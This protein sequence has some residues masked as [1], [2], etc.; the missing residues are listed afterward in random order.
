MSTAIFE[1]SLSIPERISELERLVHLA[2]VEIDRDEKAYNTPCR[3]CCILLASHLEGFL[4]DLT[5]SLIYD[6]NFHL[7]SFA[8]MPEAMKRT[9]CEKIAFYEGVPPDDINHRTKQLVKFFSDHTVPIDLQAFHYKENKNKNPSPDFVD[10]ILAKLGVPSVLSSISDGPLDNIFK[11]ENSLS[12]MIR[13]DMRKFRSYLHKFPYRTLPI[14]YTFIY[15]GKKGGKKDESLWNTYIDEILLRRH[16]IVHGD[17]MS[18]ETNT[19]ALIKDV[20]K[21]DVLMHGIMYSSIAYIKKS[22]DSKK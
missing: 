5:K 9:F 2:N 11:G 12:Y 3:A 20:E 8:N 21:M 16:N 7:K 18:N 4:K 15:S 13:R 22:I 17:T 10:G 6:L 1:V 14:K 19:V